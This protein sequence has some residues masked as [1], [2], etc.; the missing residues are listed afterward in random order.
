MS[1]SKDEK[2]NRREFFG[3]ASKGAA[4]GIAVA[5]TGGAAVAAEQPT[6]VGTYKE[7]AHVQTY[8]QSTKF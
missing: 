4:A 1:K 3:R 5:A 6:Q 8:Y 2:L 7:T